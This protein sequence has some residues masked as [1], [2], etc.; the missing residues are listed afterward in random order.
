[1]MKVDL[2]ENAEFGEKDIKITKK[3]EFSRKFWRKEMV[4]IVKERLH[5]PD[6]G[7]FGEKKRFKF[8]MFLSFYHR[9]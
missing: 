4:M 2:P 7:Y 8:M 5:S 3:K 6:T 1:M 9:A